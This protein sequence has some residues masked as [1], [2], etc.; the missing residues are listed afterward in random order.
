MNRRVRLTVRLGVD[1]LR[2]IG[3]RKQHKEA[4]DVE[5]EPSSQEQRT[6]DRPTTS[7]S[8]KKS[9]RRDGKKKDIQR[10]SDE[11]DHQLV[12][13]GEGVR[14]ERRYNAPCSANHG[15]KQARAVARDKRQ[16]QRGDNYEGARSPKCLRGIERGGHHFD[17]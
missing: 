9:G 10:R 17:A 13:I 14:R 3:G 8:Q 4:R 11:P 6:G 1:R 16:R 15:L 2:T 5:Q 12:A 7:R